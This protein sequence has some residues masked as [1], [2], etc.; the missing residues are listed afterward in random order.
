MGGRIDEHGI[1]S[2]SQPRQRASTT[3]AEGTAVT[4]QDREAANVP[5]PTTRA[6]PSRHPP[7]SPPQRCRVTPINAGSR[8]PSPARTGTDHHR[9]GHAPQVAASRRSLR[10]ARISEADV[11]AQAEPRSSDSRCRNFRERLFTPA[12]I[13]VTIAGRERAPSQAF[14]VHE[15]SARTSRR[16]QPQ[17]ANSR[18]VLLT[19]S[20]EVPTSWASSPW[21]RS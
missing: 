9:A 1:P 20:Q 12:T 14:A 16:T 13:H 8:A 17:E 3:P 19:V 2:P 6:S 7:A 18:R 15:V 11:A 4:R 5:A 10:V 21:V